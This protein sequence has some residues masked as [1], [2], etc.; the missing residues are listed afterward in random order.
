[1]KVK[2]DS[3]GVN[4]GTS[5]VF[6]ALMKWITLVALFGAYFSQSQNTPSQ[7][8]T[9]DYKKAD[10]S[11]HLDANSNEI[12]GTVD[13][14]LEILNDASSIFLDAK[15]LVS[16]NA[17]LDNKEVKMIYDGKK[18]VVQAPF[19]AGEEHVLHISFTSYPSKAMYHIDID[20][21]GLWDQLWTQGQGKYTSNWLPSMDDMNDKIIWNTS[22]TAPASKL[23]VSNGVLSQVIDGKDVKTWKYIMQKPMSSYL[24]AVVVG[25]YEVKKESSSSGLPLEYYY[26]KNQGDKVA[27]TY[28]HSK[29]IFDFLEGEIGVAFPWQ[30][31]KQIPVKD[32]LYSGMENTG[33]TVFSDVFF[34]DALGANDRSYVNVNAHELAHQWF[35]NLVT[36]TDAKHHWLHEGF[37]SYYALLAEKNLYGNSHFQHQLYEYAEA[38]NQQTARGKSTALLDPKANSLTFYQHGAWALH[39]LKDTVGEF[40]F[41]ESVTRYLIK[42]KYKN[43]T[44]N[45]FL[46]IVEEVS[47][48][49]L[50]EFKAT[51]LTSTTFPAAAALQILRKEPI[52]ENFLQLAARRIS[53]FD[54]SYYSYKE[55]LEK[56]IELELVK[57]MVAQL[58]IH[59][60]NKKYELL[61]EA[62]TLDNVEVNQLIVLSTPSIN[63]ENRELIKSMLNDDSYVTRESAL[64]LLWNDV[65]D[66][67]TFLEE[68]KQQWK[69][70]NYSLDM[71]W[72]VLAL[73]SSGYSNEELLPLLTR[74][75][76]YTGLIYSTE[77]R[78]AAFDYLINLDAMSQQNYMDLMQA[79]LHHVWRFYENARDILKAQYKREHG[80]FLIDQSFT[81]FNTE[82]KKRLKKIL[83]VK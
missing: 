36:E 56:P 44:T 8:T 74:L 75:Q 43:V 17:L 11:I 38:L 32:F 28:Q 24:L 18:L 27:S 35:G 26:Y 3:L 81:H 19:K 45:D 2:H 21:D 79:S 78:T 52:M 82:S 55:T 80:K 1:M 9:V 58:S 37:A 73:N 13:Y 22:I 64:F 48:K 62:A 83:E 54:E 71:A 50:D 25:D 34:T 5:F 33:L 60:T 40:S 30:A 51:W 39:A 12:E 29:E 7:L 72:I 53:N 46:D 31:Y 67:R 15:N 6:F 77:T 61:R 49:N 68:T 14:N 42:N 47:N 20:D 57:E 16:Y 23:A 65:S 69:E 10:V 63:V 76:S 66:K 59:N 41:R 4:C 70:M